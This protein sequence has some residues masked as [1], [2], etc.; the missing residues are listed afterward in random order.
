MAADPRSAMMPNFR[1]VH[2]QEMDFLARLYGFYGAGRGTGRTHGNGEE[3]IGGDYKD[4]IT[5]AG[6]W[7]VSMMMQGETIPK[8]TNHV[9]LSKDKKD[10]WG[11]PQLV[12]FC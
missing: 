11:I 1:N 10:Q 5:E 8:E 12:Y 6:D 9:R 7:Y 2:K 4:S 3:Q